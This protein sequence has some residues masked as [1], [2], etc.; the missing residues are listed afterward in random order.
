MSASAGTPMTSQDLAANFDMV[1]D[2]FG[3]PSTSVNSTSATTPT[4]MMKRF[5]DMDYEGW[6]LLE[7]RNPRTK[8]RH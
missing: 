3:K 6:I 4:R 5:M 8:L 2:R 1:K 7:A